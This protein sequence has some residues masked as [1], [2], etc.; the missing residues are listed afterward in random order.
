MN[1]GCLVID[2][3]RV[4]LSPASHHRSPAEPRL[5]LTLSHLLRE[6]TTPAVAKAPELIERSLLVIVVLCCVSC[7]AN[8]SQVAVD[9]TKLAQWTARP[10]PPQVNQVHVFCGEWKQNAPRGF[11]SRPGGLDPA[12]VTQFTITQT[13]NAQGIY[14]GSWSH[15]RHPRPPKFSTMFPDTCSMPQVLNSIVY[16]ATHSS[17]CPANAPH[18]AVCGPNRPPSTTRNTVPFCEANDGTIFLIA[19]GKLRNGRVNTAFP[20]R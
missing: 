2:L 9:C 15:P 18:W 7:L 5:P 20:V 16:A 14:G 11:H 6:R 4:M 17:R 13:A 10:K 8:A 3:C 12:S 19:M 1:A